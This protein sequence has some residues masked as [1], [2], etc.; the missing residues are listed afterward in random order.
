MEI[1]A[2]NMLLLCLLQRNTFCTELTVHFNRLHGCWL[3]QFLSKVSVLL[4]KKNNESIFL[5]KLLPATFTSMLA[6]LNSQV[7]G[8]NEGKTTQFLR[9]IG[10]LS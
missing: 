6:D 3:P 4:F 5:I 8:S 2:K 9:K 7:N 10:H 1:S